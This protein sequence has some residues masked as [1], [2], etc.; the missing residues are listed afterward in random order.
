MNTRS[1]FPKPWSRTIL[2]LCILALPNHTQLLLYIYSYLFNT[3]QNPYHTQVIN[4]SIV[5]GIIQLKGQLLHATDTCVLLCS[6]IH[7]LIRAL[8][9]D[10]IIH[11]IIIQ[12]LMTFY[13]WLRW[14]KHTMLSTDK[15]VRMSGLRTLSR[16]SSCLVINSSICS[17]NS[18]LG[19]YMT[20]L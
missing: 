11:M 4:Y 3:S 12:F 14:Y 6:Y 9:T 7:D 13:Y 8:F 17:L 15:C 19:S 10:Y 2:D 1:V 16:L 5:L 18:S 20:S